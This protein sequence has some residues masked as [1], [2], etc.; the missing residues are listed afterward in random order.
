LRVLDPRC[1]PDSQG[2]GARRLSSL[3]GKR[4]GL[5]WNN[6]PKGDVCLKTVGRELE[7]RFGVQ[8]VFR[9]KLRVGIGAPQEMIDEL[10]NTVDAVVIGVGD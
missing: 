4:I 5:L 6:R 7:N 10:V 2:E 8:V 9:N 1:F 3:Q